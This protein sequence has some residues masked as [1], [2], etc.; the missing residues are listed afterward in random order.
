MRLLKRFYKET[1]VMP[2]EGGGFCVALDGR[3]LR[4]PMRAALIVP[5]EGLAQAIADE[6]AAQEDTVRPQTMPMTAIACTAIDLIRAR[7]A[8]AEAEIGAYA[9]TELLCYRVDDPPE[10]AERQ[11]KIWQPLLDWAAGTHGSNL[12]TTSGILPVEQPGPAMSALLRAISRHSDMEL[13]A[14]AAA[15][16][17][18]GSLIIGLALAAGRLSA[19]EAFAAAELEGSYQIE[20]WGE[21]EEAA[22]RREALLA[23]LKSA[24][25]FFKLL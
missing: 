8:E 1:A 6:W 4:T 20:K 25:R 7:R 13:S 5:T 14:L 24:Q 19:E 12:C 17:A 21:D 15:V 9:G 10:L 11:E 2:A 16:K 18:S 22:R 3:S 23:E